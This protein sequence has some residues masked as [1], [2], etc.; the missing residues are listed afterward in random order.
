MSDLERFKMFFD[1]M[2]ITYNLMKI[3]RGYSL[4]ASGGAF[5]FTFEGVL[6]D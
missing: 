4:F 6:H 3:G 1:E 2:G 5:H